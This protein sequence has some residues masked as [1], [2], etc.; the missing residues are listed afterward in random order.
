MSARSIVDSHIHII[1]RR[2][3]PYSWA[4]RLP[5]VLQMS[6]SADD[7]RAATAGLGVA[8]AV[9]VEFLVD[10]E[11]ELTEANYADALVAADPT[12]VAFVASAPVELGAAVAEDLERLVAM[13]SVRAI[14]RVLPGGQFAAALEPNFIAG[15]RAVGAAGLPFEL[16]VHYTSLGYALELAR[17]CP[18][19]TF[20]LDHLGT[21]PIDGAPDGD[22]RSLM[23]RFGEQPNTCA[24]LSGLLAGV[25]PKGW[26]AA[27]VAAHLRV[28]IESFGPSR[29]MYGSDWPM[30]TPLASYAE[31]LAI[32]DLATEGCS[33]DELDSIYRGV[34]TETYRL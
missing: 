21:P 32:V 5:P 26:G 12:L 1:D 23:A 28:A 20:V 16:G 14:R 2:A 19:V 11:H 4:D 27:D 3:L 24:K 6:R 8:A 13:P 31:W 17:R 33:P 30:F 9:T 34:A 18:E 10:R 7:F 15:V 22:W 29:V 25:D